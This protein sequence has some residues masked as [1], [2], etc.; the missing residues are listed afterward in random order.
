VDP[1][2]SLPGSAAP[3]FTLTDQYG[4]RVSLRQFRGQAVVI[5]FVDARCTTVCPLTTVSLTEAVSMLGP[6]A[7]RHVQLLGIDANPDAT[8]VADVRA[9]SAVHQMMRS[10]TS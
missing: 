4:S 6:A 2:T 3:G 7:G 5:A 8:R 9:Y 1:G 10:W